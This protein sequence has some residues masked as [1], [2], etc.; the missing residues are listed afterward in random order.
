MAWRR[1]CL[2]HKT[3]HIKGWSC[4]RYCW[5]RCYT[6]IWYVRTTPWECRSLFTSD[7]SSV[8]R[9]YLQQLP[10][11]AAA[12]AFTLTTSTAWETDAIPGRKGADMIDPDELEDQIYRSEEVSADWYKTNIPCQVGCPARTDVANYIGLISQGR[13]DEAYVLNRRSNVV[14]GVLGRTC[15]RPCE[16]VCRRNKIDGKPGRHLLA[17]ARLARPSRVSPAAR[18]AHDH[19]RQEGRHHRRRLGGRRLRAR[20][21]RDGLSR[22]D[23]RHVCRPRRHDGRRHP[24]LAPAARG[25]ARGGATSIS[26]RSASR[27]S[28][29]PR[30]G[31]D[32]QLTD[33]LDE[34]DAVYI[35][36]GCML[37]NPLTDPYNKEVPGARA[38]WRASRACPSWRRST[39]ASRS[40][41]ASASP[42]SAAASPR[43]TAAARR[44]ASARRRSM[45]LYRRSK[46]EMPSDEYEVDEATLEHVEFI[47]LASTVEVLS[48]DGEHVSGIKM[49]RNRLGDPDASG[50]RKAIPVPGSEFVLD[51]DTVI[52]AYRPVRR[53]LVDSGAGAWAG[54]QPL[55]HPAGGPRHLDDEP[56]RPLRRWRL[57]RRRRAT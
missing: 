55:G 11:N 39:S 56:A 27:S 28:S 50:R 31:K 57:H 7:A 35:G 54:G 34:Y 42:S 52:A 17:Q 36:A 26:T 22:H 15:A 32:V 8:R 48:D 1:D 49:I 2:A 20:P 30:V 21:G 23:L 45:S 19:Q 43:W 3:R 46:E 29:T 12:V 51:V 10:T 33:L 4:V 13:F 14:P 38:A 44:S 41:S 47:Y 37:S 25:D 5:G 6:L 18:A 9:A 16:P 53:H 24:R 40:S